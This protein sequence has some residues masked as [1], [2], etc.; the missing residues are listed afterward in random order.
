MSIVTMVGIISRL[1]DMLS[2]AF[3]NVRRTDWERP[4]TAS[5]KVNSLMLHV[6]KPGRRH[7]NRHRATDMKNV[8][9]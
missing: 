7:T 5:R 6:M 8:G 9:I 1:I 4:N 2:A 3:L